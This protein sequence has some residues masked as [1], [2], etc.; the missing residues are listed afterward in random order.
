MATIIHEGAQREVPVA[1]GE[2]V[3]D[4]ALR[5]GMDLPWSCH[6]G[7]CSTCRARVTE[8]Q[9]EMAVNFS[10]EPWEVSAGYVLTC[11]ACPTTAR[12]VVDYDAV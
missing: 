11:Q 7:M 8:G 4:A 9:V 2:T 3:L 1:E 10:L 6:G 12:V 5:A